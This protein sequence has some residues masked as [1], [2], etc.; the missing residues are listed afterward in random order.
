M[1]KTTSA[2]SGT[3][4]KVNAGIAS[5]HLIS[6]HTA[7]SVYLFNSRY[8]VVRLLASLLPNDLHVIWPACSY[9][10]LNLAKVPRGLTSTRKLQDTRLPLY[11]CSDFFLKGTCCC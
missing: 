7:Y 1:L 4:H 11:K 10:A 3:V 2:A 6:S 5:T 9:S 8:F